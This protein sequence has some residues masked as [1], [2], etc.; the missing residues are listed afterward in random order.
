[1]PSI[2]DFLTKPSTLG[3]GLIGAGAA[4]DREPGEALEA[5]QALRNQFTSPVSA[6]L[7]DFAKTGTDYLTST[8]KAPA[9][10]FAAGGAYER[11]LPALQS[12]EDDILSGLQNRYNAAF[13]ASFGMQGSAVE[14]LRRAGGEL[15]RNRQVLQ[16]DLLRE[17]QTRQQNAANALLQY[18]LDVPRIQQNAA[19]RV[20]EFSRPDPTAS[21][22]AN[23]GTVLALSNAGNRG[24]TGF[25]GG[26]TGVPALDAILSQLGGG[27]GATGVADAAGGAVSAAGGG[28]GAILP[29]LG[30]FL[31]SPAGATLAASVGGFGLGNAFA[32]KIAGN[33]FQSSALGALGGAGAGILAGL[34]PVGGGIALASGALGGFLGERKEQKARK[35][36]FRR[37]DSDSQRDQ[38]YEEG[39]IGAE[40][41]QEAGVPQSVM[42]QFQA[43]VDQKAATSESPADEQADVASELNR[44]LTSA[45]FPPGQRPP[46]W[47]QRFV[48]YLVSS[49]FTASNSSYSGGAPL[50][51]IERVSGIAGLN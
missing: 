23:L 45:G 7:P 41:L 32:P 39:N 5:R 19:S 34:G 21:A 30:Q 43:F 51:L 12:S 28:L 3:L 49:T 37:Q 50:N 40:L 35:A 10:P 42:D 22:I 1:M 20:L 26:G 13:P 2:L 25:A 48:D 8:V 17:Q 15:A 11:Y 29:Q 36:E 46:A 27:G 14:A 4:L 44:L 24:T 16:A 38:V 9:D 18:G 47:K 6:L 31:T 33:Q